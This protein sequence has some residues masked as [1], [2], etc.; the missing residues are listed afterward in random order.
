[1]DSVTG[2]EQ[3]VSLM[4]FLQNTFSISSK[5]FV[6]K[7]H[8]LK[9]Y[10]EKI[11]HGMKKENLKSWLF[12]PVFIFSGTNGVSTCFYKLYFL[13]IF[14]VYLEMHSTSFT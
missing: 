1:M 5:V 9:N 3:N 10:T 11:N 12:V 8:S 4:H 6:Y 7:T 13:A 14:G 2:N